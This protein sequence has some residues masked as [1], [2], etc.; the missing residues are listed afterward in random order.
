MTCKFHVPDNGSR[1]TIDP[2]HRSNANLFCTV[3]P[4]RFHCRDCPDFE[5]SGPI[6]FRVAVSP[7]IAP[8]EAIALA[9]AA[10]GEA[11]RDALEN[12]RPAI[13]A[14]GRQLN[15][16]VTAE[17]LSQI[18]ES[19]RSAISRVARSLGLSP[20]VLTGS[21][22]RGEIP[23]YKFFLALVNAV[24]SE[25]RVSYR[26]IRWKRRNRHRFRHNNKPKP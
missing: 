11:M 24:T 19:D 20:R 2:V 14:L 5:P 15:A 6:P 12:I 7:S 8:V 13:D 21:I 18:S 3:H 16:P 10:L 23:R 4:E 26:S 1:Q 25:R 17:I 22:E 9:T